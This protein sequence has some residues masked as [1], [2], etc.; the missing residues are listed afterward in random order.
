MY[1]NTSESLLCLFSICTYVNMRDIYFD[2]PDRERAQW[3]EMSF[4]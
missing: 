3:W 2:C 4:C 1:E